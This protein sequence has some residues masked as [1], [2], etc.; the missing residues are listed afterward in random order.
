MATD[1]GKAKPTEATSENGE[2]RSAEQIQAEIETTREE[3]G[4]TVAELADKA[5]VKKQ[6]KKKVAQTKAKATAKKEEVADKVTSQ[7][8]AA[9]SKVKESAPDSAQQG[10]QQA[11]ETAQHAA[12]QASQAA[13]EN[14]LPTAAIAAFTGGLVLG[15][16][17]GRR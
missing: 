10:A 17:L 4:D 7:K 3:M 6:A 16:V 5:D 9:A 11:A 1:S 2:E 8:D 12:A 13:R 14:P 15:W